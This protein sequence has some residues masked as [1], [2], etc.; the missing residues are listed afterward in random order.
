[1]LVLV[2]LGVPVALPAGCWPCI[3]HQQHADTGQEVKHPQQDMSMLSPGAQIMG[4]CAGVASSQQLLVLH[5]T[6]ACRQ[7][8]GSERYPAGHGKAVA[9]CA[10]H[11]L[12]HCCC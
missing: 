5:L 11:G 8:A 2:G 7:R 6:A 10:Q 9:R 4:C 12:L 1:M 3:T